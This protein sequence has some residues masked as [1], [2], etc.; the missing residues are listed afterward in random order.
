MAQHFLLVSRETNR[1]ER[2][3]ER[4]DALL[5]GE[6]RDDLEEDE[7][8]EIARESEDDAEDDLD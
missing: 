2:E 8:E 4:E 7:L 6:N 1:E 3:R 5:F